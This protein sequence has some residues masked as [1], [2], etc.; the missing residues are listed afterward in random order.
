MNLTFEGTREEFESLSHEERAKYNCVIIR[1]KM[2]KI[3]VNAS[4]V[5]DSDVDDTPPIGGFHDW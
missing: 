5:I 4:F 1:P 2:P 3:E